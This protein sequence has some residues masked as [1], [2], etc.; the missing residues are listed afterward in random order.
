M[1]READ[2]RGRLAHRYAAGAGRAGLSVM[3]VFFMVLFNYFVLSKT[4][5]GWF[6]QSD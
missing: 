5:T 4:L 3:P 6:Y 1:D 2:G